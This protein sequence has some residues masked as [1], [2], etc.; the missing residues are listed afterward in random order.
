MDPL[1]KTTLH[2]TLAFLFL[3]LLSPLLFVYVEYKETNDVEE[4]Y[5]MLRLLYDS[6][7]SKC[8]ITI[9]EFNNFSKLA[10]D[11]LSE[12]KPQWTYQ[13]ATDFVLQA[14]TTIGKLN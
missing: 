12:P 8:N 10:Y 2:R 3:A 14:F 9:E 6:M 7:A 11:A 4:K 5:K 1:I 13:L